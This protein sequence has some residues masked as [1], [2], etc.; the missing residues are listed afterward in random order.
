M[1]TMLALHSSAVLLALAAL[2]APAASA[3]AD[4]NVRLAFPQQSRPPGWTDPDAPWLALEEVSGSYQ[5]TPVTARY[6]VTGQS[7]RET[8]PVLVV[9][10]PDRGILVLLAS[11]I[12]KPGPLPGSWT[13]R[14]LL[15]PG[16]TVRIALPSGPSTITATGLRHPAPPDP[17]I[18]DYRLTVS[19]R[20]TNQIAVDFPRGVIEES[21]PGI[22]W[23]GDLDR[24][25]HL[26]LVVNLSTHY[27]ATD[28]HLLLSTAA[29]PGTLFMDVGQVFRG[30]C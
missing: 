2:I 3:Q 28:Y 16:D 13:P 27:A 6:E 29:S 7:C 11:P 8:D 18:E 25:T 30:G 19:A 4:F 23:A 17:W 9:S 10:R 15:Y 14:E 20:G 22:V 21:S 24:D 12:L 1:S 26:D 5:L